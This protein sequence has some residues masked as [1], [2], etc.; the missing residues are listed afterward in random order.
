MS[1]RTLHDL[2]SVGWRLSECWEAVR[3]LTPAALATAAGGPFLVELSGAAPMAGVDASTVS[4]EGGGG[5]GRLDWETVRVHVVRR[6]RAGPTGRITVGR[7]VENDVVLPH[8]MVSK[9][10][11]FFVERDGRYGLADAGSRNGTSIGGERLTPGTVFAVADGAE[12]GVAE[13]VYLFVM[14]AT[15][16]D[17][18]RGMFPRETG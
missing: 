17:T 3:D 1:R 11:A 15:L 10:H 13:A 2:P 6:R 9:A 12:V 7:G 4:P 5:S 16:Q 18:L 14:P 8:A